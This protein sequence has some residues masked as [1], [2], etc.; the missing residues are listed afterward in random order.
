MPDERAN[1]K[2]QLYRD[3][4]HEDK[5]QSIGQLKRI[6]TSIQDDGRISHQ[7]QSQKVPHSQ[8]FVKS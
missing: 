7:Q 8:Y 2:F 1:L 4:E 3:Y 5:K 6:R